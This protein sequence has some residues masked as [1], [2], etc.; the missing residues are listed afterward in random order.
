MDITTLY[1]MTKAASEAAANSA[2]LQLRPGVSPD[3]LPYGSYVP[4]ANQYNKLF[5]HA[6][7]LF[8]KEVQELFEPIDLGEHNSLGNTPGAYW[9]S[10]LDLT[11]VNLATLAAYLQSKIPTTQK[12]VEAVSDLIAANLRPSIFQ[13]PGRE[14]DIQNIVEILLRSRGYDYR[15]EK[16]HIPYS[17]KTFIPDFTIEALHLALEIKLCD[18]LKRVKELVD[19]INADIPAY[20]TR[21]KNIIFAIYDMGFIR[22]TQE[23][24]ASIEANLNVYVNIVKK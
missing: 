3:Y 12:E 8:G 16:I 7:K 15:R 14:K 9:K 19:E 2:N 13:D 24:R 22:D 10:H 6:Y 4:Y 20:Q 5:V 11:V 23:F 1:A 21:Y 18:S 17:A